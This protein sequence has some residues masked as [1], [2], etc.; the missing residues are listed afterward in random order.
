MAGG[1]SHFSGTERMVILTLSIMTSAYAPSIGQLCIM[2]VL[3]VLSPPLNLDVPLCFFCAITIYEVVVHMRLNWRASFHV[4]QICPQNSSCSTEVSMFASAI[5]VPPLS[6]IILKF[7][8]GGNGP[9]PGHT[10]CHSLCAGCSFL[11][12][13]SF[14]LLGV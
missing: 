8:N 11:C 12:F 13:V 4:R 1:N 5:I 14:G 10:W 9:R 7:T 2:S 3:S 6:N